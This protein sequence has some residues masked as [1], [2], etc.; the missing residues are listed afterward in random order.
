M[1]LLHQH[2]GL[3]LI[4]ARQFPV[5]RGVNEVDVARQANA[6]NN[7]LRDRRRAPAGRLSRQLNFATKAIEILRQ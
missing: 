1:G 4:H 2:L 6:L 3:F 7:A 5:E